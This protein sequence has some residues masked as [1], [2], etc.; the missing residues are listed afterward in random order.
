MPRESRTFRSLAIANLIDL[1]EELQVNPDDNTSLSLLDRVRAMPD[2]ESW[3]RLYGL[4]CP[5]L[6]RWMFKYGVQ[7]ADADDLIHDVL[8]VVL[9]ELPKFEHNQR[10]GAFRNWLRRILGY[11]LQEFWRAR[12]Y[13]PTAPGGSSILDEI[14]QLADDGTALSQLWNREH[15]ELVMARLMEA[16]RPRFATQ[17]WEI[18]QRLMMDGWRPDAVAAD[19]DVPLSKVYVAKSRVLNALRHEAGGLVDM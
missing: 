5:M 18:F 16:V 12:R 9:Q 6:R 17:T 2:A 13:R 1:V 10:A 15:D 3:E 7:D 14:N 11:R 19:F 4:Y 8:G